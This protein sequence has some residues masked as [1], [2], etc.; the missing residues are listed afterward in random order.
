MCVQTKN[1]PWERPAMALDLP[2]ISHEFPG[3]DYEELLGRMSENFALPLVTDLV[4]FGAMYHSTPD[5]YGLRT[6]PFSAFEP[7]TNNVIKLPV[8]SQAVEWFEN[9]ALGS[10]MWSRA[11]RWSRLNHDCEVRF[12]MNCNCGLVPT[13]ALSSKTWTVWEQNFNLERQ[14]LFGRT[15][16]VYRTRNDISGTN[17]TKDQLLIWLRIERCLS[18]IAATSEKSYDSLALTS[19]YQ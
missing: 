15:N 5:S 19:A 12:A 2:E 10:E 7:G 4:L 8:M 11:S 9:T 18:S 1:L 17:M 16:V 13:Q 14:A 3:V 6:V